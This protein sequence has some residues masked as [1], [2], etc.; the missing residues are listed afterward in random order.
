MFYNFNIA[1]IISNIPLNQDKSKEIFSANLLPIKHP[2]ITNN[3]PRINEK[4]MA[5][6]QFILAKAAPKPTANPSRDRAKAR[7]T[8]SEADNVWD[9]SLSASS[10]FAYTFNM[11]FKCRAEKDIFLCIFLCFLIK[12]FIELSNSFII[13]NIV[14]I[15]KHIILISFSGKYGLSID[16]KNN[17]IANITVQ[18]IL[19][20]ITDEN[21]IFI[22]F[23]PY[24]KLATNASVDKAIINN[25]GS[26]I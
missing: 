9:K 13:P 21:G 4:I 20:I 1:N 26:R 18:T 10:G 12:A 23:V 8:A 2:S 15:I 24:E 3:I 6:K 22:L 5:T 19:I 11:N 16:P 25:K 7:D 14:K 17:D